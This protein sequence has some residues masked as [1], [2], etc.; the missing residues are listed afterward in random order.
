MGHGKTLKYPK[1]KKYVSPN[2][3][4]T[5]QL[6]DKPISEE[7]HQKRLELLRQIGVLKD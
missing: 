5:A 7:E 4:H 6:D 1:R 3:S 2:R